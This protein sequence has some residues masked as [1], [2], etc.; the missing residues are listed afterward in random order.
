MTGT[1]FV[2]IMPLRERKEIVIKATGFPIQAK[3]IM[4]FQA[5]SRETRDRVIGAGSGQVIILMALKALVTQW[6]EPKGG[7]TVV[8]GRAI[9]VAVSAY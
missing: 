5:V 2:Y 6:S 9:H 4:A 1:A 3:R 7:G 8:T